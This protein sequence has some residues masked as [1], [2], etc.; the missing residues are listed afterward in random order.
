MLKAL[1]ARKIAFAA[2]DNTSSVPSSDVLSTVSWVLP[3]VPLPAA[4]CALQTR[5]QSTFLTWTCCHMTEMEDLE[6]LEDQCLAGFNGTW[7]EQIFR[8]SSMIY[9][10]SIHTI[11]IMSFSDDCLPVVMIASYSCK[12]VKHRVTF[13]SRGMRTKHELLCGMFHCQGGRAR[14]QELDLCGRLRLW[15]CIQWHLR[16]SS[17]FLQSCHDLGG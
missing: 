9:I 11:G 16:T 1:C 15:S 5:N 12:D 6:D 10:T 13:A 8:M 2:G 4:F 7:L 3:T 17:L 14:C